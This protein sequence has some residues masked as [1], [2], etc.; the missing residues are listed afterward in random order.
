MKKIHSTI[1][2]LAMMVAALSFTACSSDDDEDGGGGGGDSKKT[3]IIDGQAYYAGCVKDFIG[4]SVVQ[5]GSGMRLHISA[6]ENPHSVYKGYKISLHISPTKVSELR[7]GQVFNFVDKTSINF[8]DFWAQAATTWWWYGTDGEMLIKDIKETELTV[9]FKN[10]AIKRQE[11]GTEHTIE[12][13][14]ILQNSI[15]NNNGP[16][17]FS[18]TEP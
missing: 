14:A 12:G 18:E 13:T 15:S 16:M 1:M 9:Q 5:S 6:I 10:F 8:G 11:T 17:P 2:M 7:V 4:G 3:L